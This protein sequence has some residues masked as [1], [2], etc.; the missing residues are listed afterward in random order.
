M[1][2]RSHITVTALVWA[3][4]A[5]PL[6]EIAGR[7]LTVAEIVISTVVC[8]SAALWPDWDHPSATMAH[9]LGPISKTIAHLV[10]GL[11]RGHRHGTHNLWF[12]I[13][14]GLATLGLAYA[15]QSI[16]SVTMPENWA[17][18]ALMVFLAYTL[19]MTL[20]LAVAKSTGLGD[21]I[22]LVQAIAFV[23]AAAVLVPGHWW[24]MPWAVGAGALLHCLEDILTTGGLSWFLRPVSRARICLP[25]CGDTGGP[26][27]MV[28][29]GVS[30]AALLWVSIATIAGHQWWTTSWL[31]TS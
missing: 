4:A 1:M 3:A 31:F 28:V 2:G 6:A 12:C 26:G 14:L 23:T 30:G 15:P 24:W 21:G 10:H 5:P 17:S 9:T 27:E 16:G 29:A 8:A 7:P 20:G 18:L 22:Y 11:A 19:M 13:A 25:V